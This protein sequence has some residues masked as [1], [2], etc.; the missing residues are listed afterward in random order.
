M[1]HYTRFFSAGWP[2]Q[3]SVQRFKDSTVQAQVTDFV[4]EPEAPSRRQ[5][6]VAYMVQLM[7]KPF[8]KCTRIAIYWL[9]ESK[10]AA[11][12]QWS[13]EAEDASYIPVA[14]SDIVRWFENFKECVP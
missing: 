2:E 13:T 7:S 11:E 5:R 9:T 10:G 14:R 6:H 4:A 12:S 3:A 8:G 1:G